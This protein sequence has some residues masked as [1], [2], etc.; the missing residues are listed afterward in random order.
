MGKNTYKGGK[1]W[2][3]LFCAPIPVINGKKALPACPKPAIHPI[4]GASSHGGMILAAKFI[5]IGYHG[6]SINPRNAAAN[7][8]PT[9]EGTNHITNSILNKTRKSE[10]QKHNLRTP[11]P[12]R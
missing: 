5:P 2:M 10:R 8:F 7:A 3:L 6:P 1:L 9:T 4:D 12:V 11:T